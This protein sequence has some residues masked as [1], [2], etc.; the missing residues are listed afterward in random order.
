MPNGHSEA[1]C[2]DSVF[3]LFASVSV[4]P[5]RFVSLAFLIAAPLPFRYL[6][7]L[8]GRRFR[9]GL[10]PSPADR[11]F[12]PQ[13]A[14]SRPSASKLLGARAP[15]GR[16]LP[17]RCRF[18]RAA[19]L[20]SCRLATGRAAGALARRSAACCARARARAARRAAGSR[21]PASAL[22][23][24]RALLGLDG[25]P[26]RCAALGRLLS[27]GHLSSP[28]VRTQSA[29]AAR[30]LHDARQ[31]AAGARREAARETAPLAAARADRDRGRAPR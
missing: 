10:C 26:L 17:R 22:A 29:R 2:Y 16:R 24:L 23:R 5:S 21:R 31:R 30:G 1:G 9:A 13:S 12:A 11:Q 25:A 6:A 14:F 28:W 15:S 27:L 4:F 19:A 18:A 20:G 8:A 3:G 7:Q